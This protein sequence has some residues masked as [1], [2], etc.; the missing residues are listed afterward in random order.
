MKWISV[1]D[2]MP[3][4]R[5]KI[6]ITDG[7]IVTACQADVDKMWHGKIYPDGCEFSG[8]EWGWNFDWESITYWMPL[9]LPP[10]K[11]LS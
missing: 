10:K 11:E 1:N 6:L 4:D 9:A 2:K 3:K 7:I 5:Q 8:Y